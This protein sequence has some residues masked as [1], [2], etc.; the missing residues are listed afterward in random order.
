LEQA[1]ELAS[2][3]EFV[4][5]WWMP[6][7]PKV[8]VYRCTRTDDHAAVKRGART[9]ALNRWIDNNIMHP[10]VLPLLTKLNVLVPAFMPV[11][12]KLVDSLVLA[13]SHKTGPPELLL[14]TP[15]PLP[16]REAEYALHIDQTAEAMRRLRHIIESAQL[17]IDLITEIRFVAA[18]NNW[19]SV[20]F[21]RPSVH[22][23]AYTVCEADA[24]VYF[25]AFEEA[26]LELGGR[27]HLGKE[28]SLG[29]ARLRDL[30][31]RENVERFLAAAQE[32]D[33]QGLFTKSWSALALGLERPAGAARLAR[34]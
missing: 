26:M 4:K 31:P 13:N 9:L 14:T 3:A 34:L 5:F 7:S 1:M 15:N 11:F 19:L 23:G 24:D 10:A 6:G 28:A 12:N 30:L 2:S 16:H 25:S 21:G 22:V 18:D 33:P 8:Q 27:P 20:D 32:L 17:R 29:F